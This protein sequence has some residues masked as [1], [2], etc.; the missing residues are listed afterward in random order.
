MEIEDDG[1][2]DEES[3]VAGKKGKGLMLN[4]LTAGVR[5][6]TPFV[7][8]AS[9]KLSRVDLDWLP[10][11]SL[12]RLGVLDIGRDAVLGFDMRDVSVLVVSVIAFRGLDVGNPAVA[13]LKLDC[14]IATV[15]LSRVE[16]AELD[17][18]ILLL[19][20]EDRMG[21]AL[22]L[23]PLL[24][25]AGDEEEKL[26]LAT[27]DDDEVR[28]LTVVEADEEDKL[29]LVAE[30][31]RDDGLL[32]VVEAGEGDILLVVVEDDRD[33][34]LLLVDEDE[35]EGR[36]LLANEGDEGVETLL[37]VLPTD[38]DDV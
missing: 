22:L 10:D 27:K 30:A 25:A 37:R 6:G 15:E 23:L 38:D 18:T 11:V 4:L 1:I 24:L 36:L 14:V 3:I 17:V 12:E 8:V 33:D 5:T 26:L 35:E 13:I 34:R 2:A 19:T 7:R 29:L 16:A 20:I 32:L 31:G 21:D 9:R 28:L